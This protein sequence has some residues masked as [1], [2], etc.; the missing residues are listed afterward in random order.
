MAM[1]PVRIITVDSPDPAREVK[2]DLICHDN[3]VHVIV[4]STPA[5]VRNWISLTRCHRLKKLRLG[6]LVV[7]L[8]VQST[9]AGA[10]A[11]INLCVANRCLIFQLLPA[12]QSP[13]A[14]THF[15][16]KPDITFVVVGNRTVVVDMLLASHHRL[17][18]HRLTDLRHLANSLIMTSLDATMETL[19]Y[20][21]LE[22]DEI[23][24]EELVGQNYWDATRL[25]ED[26]VKYASLDAFLS[27][28]IGMDLKA[29]LYPAA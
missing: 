4:T 15:L 13:A 10:A 16:S 12:S 2:Y 11:T 22:W 6:R 27:Y 7:G 5:V 3:C 9:P 25:S 21:V 14:L 29:W 23:E 26:Q 28:L 18:V 1:Y 24:K 17:Q 8:G 19:A 20:E